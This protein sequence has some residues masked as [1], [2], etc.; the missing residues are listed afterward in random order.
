MTL[1]HA[2]IDVAA[3]KADIVERFRVFADVVQTRETSARKIADVLRTRRAVADRRLLLDLLD[4]LAAGACSVLEREYLLLER[5]HGLPTTLE[6]GVQRQGV[7]TIRGRR[8]FQD[9]V[10]GKC[11]LVIELDGRAFHDSAT[12]RDH[13]ALRDLETAV[14]SDR[15]TVRLTYGLVLRDGC[16]TAWAIACLLRR[17]GWTGS[18]VR[19]PDC[20]EDLK[21]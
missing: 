3:R 11:L 4:D 12:A 15:L 8:A 2:A 10:H 7:A 21:S 19:C 13:D 17:R 18:F 6:D 20:P 1:E 14:G 9:V 16:R 5:R